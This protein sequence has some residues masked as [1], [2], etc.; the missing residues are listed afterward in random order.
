[1]RAC[2]AWTTHADADAFASAF[3]YFAAGPVARR[4]ITQVFVERIKSESLRESDTA[5]PSTALLARVL[6]T[7]K[8]ASKTFDEEIVAKTISSFRE[9]SEEY[10]FRVTVPRKKEKENPAVDR[11]RLDRAHLGSVRFLG[12]L[13]KFRALD[14]EW[15]FAFLKKCTET[16][17][18]NAVNAA[19]ALLQTC[20][21]YL[22]RRR[23]TS[24]R[25]NALLDVFFKLKAVH[26]K[27]LEPGQSE[28][29][30]AT[31][32]ACRPPPV[33]ARTKK[34]QNPTR[35]YVAFVVDR[36]CR[37]WRPPPEATSETSLDGNEKDVFV[38]KDRARTCDDA[39]RRCV[40][41]LRKVNWAEHG[42]Y[43]VSRLLKGATR[44]GRVESS[45]GAARAVATLDRFRENA[46]QMFVDA[47]MEETCGS[48]RARRRLAIAI[49][50]E[51]RRARPRDRRGVRREARPG[52]GGVRAPLF[53][54]GGDETN[55][56]GN[57][58][59]EGRFVRVFG[60]RFQ[61]EDG[62]RTRGPT[63]FFAR[64]S[65][66]ARR[67]P[68]SPGAGRGRRGARRSAA[69]TK[70]RERRSETQKKGLVR[71]AAVPGVL[72]AV[73]VPRRRRVFA[74][75]LG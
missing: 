62:P 22:A 24:H 69:A 53:A 50:A 6:A 31:Y 56:N 29:V 74:G 49:R 12:E 10:F 4:L 46:A 33:A 75:A 64:V 19:C 39:V 44:S 36:L 16:F 43:A 52:D 28:L 35:A 71:D 8:S 59:R 26:A 20:G 66:D 5:T 38:K 37:E 42:R 48:R 57:G 51:A 1:L 40:R 17:A 27:K 14:P 9:T 3:C 23:D 41:Q 54:V 58:N 45:M 11:K 63:G 61:R 34:K 70:K 67:V 32:L 72:A 2:G 55:G 73:R 18:G 7:L 30:D 65:R 25:A 13:V 47:L 68:P 21:R 15:A 60:K